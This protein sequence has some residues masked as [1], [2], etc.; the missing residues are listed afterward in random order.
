MAFLSTAMD[1][2]TASYKMRKTIKTDLDN[3]MKTIE[4]KKIHHSK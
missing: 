1:E 2:D 4:E 3:Y